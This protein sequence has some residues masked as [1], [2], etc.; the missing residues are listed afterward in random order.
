MLCDSF[1][2]RSSRIFT[3]TC[4]CVQI[5]WINSRAHAQI[6]LQQICF[7]SHESALFLS[8]DTKINSKMLCK[9]AST[10]IQSTFYSHVPLCA[11]W[12][13]QIALFKCISLTEWSHI[14]ARF[15]FL[16]TLHDW[17][18]VWAWNYAIFLKNMF[19]K[20]FCFKRVQLPTF[21]PRLR[22]RQERFGAEN[23]TPGCCQYWLPGFGI[24]AWSTNGNR[25]E[26]YDL[27][28]NFHS[29]FWPVTFCILA[30]L[31]R[32]LRAIST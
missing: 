27:G 1:S 21:P 9:L 7:W 28:R 29:R 16:S 23:K 11:K 19:F 17:L 25:Q 20:K 10:A 4:H 8:L 2:L 32:V 15:F 12:H 13:F 3:P 5:D 6:I 14:W 18:S 24:W 22:R 31:R 26:T 30:R